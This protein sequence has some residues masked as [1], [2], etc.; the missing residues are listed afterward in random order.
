MRAGILQYITVMSILFGLASSCR[1]NES[2]NQPG[3]SQGRNYHFTI[4]FYGVAGNPFWT[5]VVAGARETAS[6][7]SC[8]LEVQYANND[9]VRQNDII[10]TAIV[11]RVDGL[12][13][14]INLDDA[15]DEVVESALAHGIPVIAFNND[16]SQGAAGNFRMAY[17]G[18][19]ETAAGYAITKRLVQASRL[20]KGDHVVCPVE[21]PEATYATDRY[22]GVKKALDEAGVTSEVLNTGA[23][24]LEDALNR[25]TQYL[26][27]HPETAAILAMGGM[28]ME[29]A[30]QAAADAG[31]DIPNAGFDLTRVIAENIQNGKTLAAVDQKP[32][33]QGSFT[34]LQLYYYKE[35]NL[36]P[37][38]IN[39]GGGIIDQSNVAKVLELAD[40]VR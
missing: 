36:L 11:N 37:C 19:D 2:T 7:L 33:Y 21:H 35:Y 10:E 14:N 12:G 31:L 16:D 17:V 27:G 3:R 9:P 39:T 24:S 34:V 32:F 30:P 5:K 25:L 20:R 22:A 1:P 28:P 15:Y 40:T 38:D 13:I 18:Q 8:E 6:A 23:V 4:V 29:V 26:L